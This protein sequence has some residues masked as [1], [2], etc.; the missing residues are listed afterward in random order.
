MDR[1]ATVSN[2]DP[3]GSF[4]QSSIFTASRPTLRASRIDGSLSV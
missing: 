4:V 1:G 2:S 3:A